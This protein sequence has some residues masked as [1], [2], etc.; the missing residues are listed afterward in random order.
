VT[1]IRAFITGEQGMIACAVSHYL[2]KDSNFEL[3][4]WAYDDDDDKTFTA[5]YKNPTFKELD[6]CSER[7]REKVRETKPDIIIHTA[8]YAGTD[9]CE[10]S[11]KESIDS[12]VFGTWN[13]VEAAN[14]VNA[15]VIFLSTTATYDPNNYGSGWISEDAPQSPKTIYGIGKYASELT[16][17]AYTQRSFVLR[18][19]F[20]LGAILDDPLDFVNPE[21][22][23][24][25]DTSSNITKLIYN[26]RFRIVDNPKFTLDPKFLKDYM[27][28]D[29]VARAIHLAII[30]DWDGIYNISLMK[31]RTW[32]EFCSI[33]AQTLDTELSF[34]SLSEKDYLR[35]HCVDSRRLRNL[36][37]EP[38][39]TDVRSI[40]ANI[41]DKIDKNEFVFDSRIMETHK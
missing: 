10:Q 15:R 12:N 35:N 22:Y 38:Q 40:V 21:L 16:V 6:I 5:A 23:Y 20:A 34:R 36:G 9:S 29:D 1:K 19:C 25:R 7:F 28:V 24:L 27:S 33:V 32:S 4:N 39:Y 30:N 17:R 41:A 3:V 18:P 8:A 14:E 26:T 11:P 37:W 31:P 13:V 2:L